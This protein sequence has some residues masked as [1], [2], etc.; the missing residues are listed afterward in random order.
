MMPSAIS[1]LLPE[2]E[3]PGLVPAILQLAHVEHNVV[4]LA[5]WD[6]LSSLPD[7]L[8]VVDVGPGRWGLAAAC[9]LR[10]R[11][12]PFAGAIVLVS[13]ERKTDLIRTPNGELLHM[14]GVTFVRLPVNPAEFAGVL[15]RLRPPKERDLNASIVALRVGRICARAKILMHRRGSAVGQPRAMAN[16]LRRAIDRNAPHLAEAAFIFERSWRDAAISLLQ[17]AQDCDAL[18]L[19]ASER[20]EGASPMQILV[21]AAE[22]VWQ[23]LEKL[24]S[25]LASADSPQNIEAQ[26]WARKTI[27]LL[28]ALAAASVGIGRLA[29][30]DARAQRNG[31]PL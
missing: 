31:V 6:S 12:P 10:T 7:R 20:Q 8:V 30:A 28:D 16:S 9:K 5:N 19:E 14:A 4:R 2:D 21:P 26:K 3:A 11:L 13:F 25:S 1:V 18:M 23:A 27:R 22:L 29:N 15:S 17:W 24:A